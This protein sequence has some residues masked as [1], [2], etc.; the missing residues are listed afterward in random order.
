MHGHRL[1]LGQRGQAAC[2]QQREALTQLSVYSALI[3][4]QQGRRTGFVLLVWIT[5][6][7][8]I[9]L[10]VINV[11]TLYKSSFKFLFE[12]WL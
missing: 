11:C 4:A 5:L 1:I 7:M 6:F 3:G 2:C 8:R 10:L 12:A 9:S